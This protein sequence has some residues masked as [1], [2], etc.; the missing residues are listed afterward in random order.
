MRGGVPKR[1]TATRKD[2]QPC[3]APVL[4]GSTYCFAHSP[5]RA[6]ER[7]QARRKGGAST[8]SSARL[9]GLVPP[10][11][12]SVYDTLESALQEVHDGSLDPKQASAMAA[13]ARAMVATLTSGELEQRLRDMEARLNGAAEGKTGTWR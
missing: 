4:D 6:E 5:E 1:C 2:G 3:T 7:E 10:R 13:I 9:R 12:L 8:A 11:L